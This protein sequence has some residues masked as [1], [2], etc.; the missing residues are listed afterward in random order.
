M[1]P[2]SLH[3]ASG[4]AASRRPA[5]EIDPALFWSGLMLLCFGLVM[6]YSASIAYAEGHRAF[7]YA[8]Y[9]LLRHG[10]FLVIGLV[11]GAAAFMVPV[12][13]WQKAAP[14]LFLLGVVLLAVVLIPGVG[15]EVN[16]ARRWI[17]LG[18]V[19]VQAS[20]LMK[21]FVVLYAADYAVR[22]MNLMHDV[23]RA[24][25]PMASVMILV[26]WLLLKEPDFGA[27][28]IIVTIA[29]S[30]LFL[31]GMKM[32]L[33]AAL[34]VGLL[35]TFAVL[36]IIEPYRLERMFSFFDP[37]RDPFGKGYQLTQ[38]EIAF[39][40][41]EWF[42]VG[43]GASVQKLFY[44][45]EAH[46]D[47]LLAIIAEE[48]GFVGV[49][50]VVCLFALL[51]HRIFAVGRQCV[52]LNRVYPALVTM[53]IGIWFGV[54]GFINMGVNVG[55]LPTKGLTLPLM[56]FGGSG[57]VANCIAFGILLRVDWGN[58]QIMRGGTS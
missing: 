56:S 25:L 12:K 38:S 53:G 29:M 43:L 48:L 51:A 49:S 57:I 31:A 30:I 42:G 27:L 22:K 44:L 54:Q 4:E 18:M 20:E 39:G 28:V 15:R 11:C 13:R 52:Q 6:V 16:G 5:Y 2:V 40:R 37:W 50:A 45:P 34:F 3:L 7:G 10:S 58:R 24:F 47:F 33:F 8:S 35:V 14:W 19:N 46:T 9:F 55:L 36:I 26:G 32:R 21:L 23:K 41:G 17:S 1:I